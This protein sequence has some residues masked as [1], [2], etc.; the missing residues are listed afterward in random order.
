MENTRILWW[1]WVLFLFWNQA[2]AQDFT[3][4]QFGNASHVFNPGCIGKGETDIRTM[5]LY[6][7][8]WFAGGTPYQTFLVSAESK[9]K[10]LPKY[11]KQT[12]VG[13]TLADDQI[14]D[15]LW[16]NTWISGGISASKELDVVHRHCIS[17]G[18]SGALLLR[19]F[20][21]QNLT[22][23][24]QFESGA[25]EFNP[26]IASGENLDAKRQAFFQINSGFLYD[27]AAS[28]RLHISVG[29]S[30]LWLYRPNEALSTLSPDYF[31]R[32]HSRF[33]GLV[34]A[35]WQ[36]SSDLAAEPQVFFSEQGKAREFNFGGWLVFSSH[37]GKSGVWQ[38]GFG[39]FSRMGDA[40]IPA[41]RLGNKNV[42][43]Q[44]SYD[45]TFSD[46]KNAD[47]QKK[48]MGIGGMGSLEFSLVYGFDIRPKPFRSFPQPC[49]TF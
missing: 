1:S 41:L 19:Q 12:A 25:F 21:A 45:A 11:L 8:Q 3:L 23:E 26:S 5:A 43:G 14:G 4:T 16:R 13:I 24:N 40:I 48:F 38:T 35:N 42:Y 34:T 36:I 39:C 2:A 9:L 33:T 29:S 10:L 44:L 7:N 15:G 22:F 37:W 27:Y 46:A 32:M 18:I 30:A 31:A 20:N 17:F 28:D 6:R 47:N 49:Q